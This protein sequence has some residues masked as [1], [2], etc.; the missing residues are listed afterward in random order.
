MNK[1][2]NILLYID[3][4]NSVCNFWRGSGVFNELEREGYITTKI[5]NW[6]ESLITL[7]KYHI[8]YFQ[9]PMFGECLQQVLMAKDCGLK[10]WV[11]LD[12]WMSLPDNHPRKREYDSYF[13][14]KSFK[15]IMNA[16]DIITVTNDMMKMAYLRFSTK[17][18]IIPNAINDFV[19]KQRAK[20]SNK[21]I[22]WRGNDHHYADLLS[23]LESIKTFLSAYPD[24]YFIT[25]GQRIRELS[26]VKNH[27]HIDNLSLHDY[28]GFMLNL[29][30]AIVIAPLERNKL[31]EL[32]SNIIWQE[33]TIS[34]AV[35]VTPSF[36]TCVD[37][38][39]YVANIH[40]TLIDIVK[41]QRKIDDN[42]KASV[43]TLS[44]NYSLSKVNNLRLEIIN[45]L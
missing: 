4:E 24:W 39:Q 43:N 42:F 44:K 34:G 28:F 14:L 21:V 25:I 19:F 36:S 8:A 37:G 9:R 12:D 7:R 22:L 1:V 38:I 10:V 20:S 2:K 3:R 27:K 26:G 5:S 23:Q 35:C 41:N 30:P 6:K 33:A 11:D 29:N 17:I 31:N 40:D 32:K 13:D 16:A 18:K 45:S 15:T